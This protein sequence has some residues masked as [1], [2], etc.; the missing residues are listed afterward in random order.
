MSEGLAKDFLAWGLLSS[1][2][3][4]GKVLHR[5]SHCEVGAGR[6]SSPDETVYGFIHD[7]IQLSARACV[8]LALSMSGVIGRVLGV[9]VRYYCYRKLDYQR[10]LMR[11]LMRLIF[12][13]VLMSGISVAQA[14]QPSPTQNTDAPKEQ[15][16][17]DNQGT[18]EFPFVIKIVP[19][20]QDKTETTDRQGPKKGADGWTL[21][22]KI[23]AIATVAA[24]LQFLA[25]LITVCIMVRNGRRQLRAYVAYEITAW[26]GINDKRPLA[27]QVVL[28]NNGQTPARLVKIFGTIEIMPFPL[29]NGYELPKLK[30]NVAQAVSVFPGQPKNPPIGWITA[31]QAFT[32]DEI[33]EITSDASK[34]RAYLLGQISYR[35][36]FNK[37]RDTFFRQFLDPKSVQRNATGQIVTFVWANTEDGND[38]R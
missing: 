33:A 22:D 29:P 8:A 21:S 18:Q 34:S 30:E 4:H 32:A 36:I 15:T 2:R 11:L 38:F 17:S 12:A 1:L 10:M 28:I 27:V 31:E 25:L 16:K 13:L 3:S 26:R 5:R 19:I 37:P 23:A 35:D 14:Q 7:L 20:Q 9:N 24:F 6:R